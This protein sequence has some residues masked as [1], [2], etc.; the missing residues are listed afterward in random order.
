MLKYIDDVVEAELE[1]EY[2]GDRGLTI[3]A[4]VRLHGFAVPAEV[5]VAQHQ[6]GELT[7]KRQAIDG[8]RKK[9]GELRVALMERGITPL[10]VLPREVWHR[11]CDE[12]GLFRLYPDAHG[13]Q[14]FNADVVTRLRAIPASVTL[15]KSGAIIGSTV[16]AALTSWLVLNFFGVFDRNPMNPWLIGVIGAMLFTAVAATINVNETVDGRVFRHNVERYF[17]TRTWPEILRDVLYPDYQYS[18]FNRLELRLPD[19]PKEVAEIIVAL[20]GLTPYVAAEAA[21]IQITNLRDVFN[22]ERA[23]QIEMERR[24]ALGGDPIIYVEQRYD[25]H[26]PRGN[27]AVA[28]IAQY[29]GFPMEKEVIDRVVAGKIV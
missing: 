21:A 29:G 4:P 27:D 3:P 19:P 14:S 12:Y 24:P 18:H 23:A 16:L 11:L 17:A 28:I 25:G 10:A 22:S 6:A 13:K 7:H 9:A 15:L 5:Q 2:Q 1:R 20:R 26:V 8:Y